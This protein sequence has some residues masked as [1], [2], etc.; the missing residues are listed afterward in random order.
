MVRRDGS[1]NGM[2]LAGLQLELRNNHRTRL[3]VRASIECRVETRWGDAVV[4]CGSCDA[5]GCWQVERGLKLT[6]DE[7]IYPVWRAEP[8]L[9][10]VDDA[11]EF[12]FVLVR[13]DGS[14][15]WEPLVNNR[16]LMLPSTAEEL[17]VVADWGSPSASPFAASPS[18]LLPS[19]AIGRDHFAIPSSVGS[20]VNSSVHATAGGGGY[21]GGG[22][23]DRSSDPASRDEPIGADHSLVERLL[24]VTHHLPL[25]L[26]RE[27][28]GS[29]RAEWD[30]SSLLATSVQGGR[31][32]LGALHL[33]V[34]FVGLTR[35]QVPPECE[36]QVA[37][38]CAA[39]NCVPV[40]LPP[41]SAGDVD[42][43]GFASQ[44]LWPLMHNQL[45]DRHAGGKGG[46]GTVVSRMWEAYVATNEAFAAR[47]RAALRPGDMVWVH[48]YHLLLLPAIL[49]G[50]MEGAA[51]GSSRDLFGRS[52]TAQT[53]ANSCIVSLFLHTPFPSPEVWR[54]VPYRKE[55]LQGE[56]TSPLPPS[57]LCPLTPVCACASHRHARGERGRLPPLRIRSS[58]YDLMP[59][60]ARSR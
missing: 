40:F 30:G 15:E 16:R 59:P 41:S 53:T 9:H 36:A 28:D 17:Q 45:P 23:V 10:G 60:T 58:L 39:F 5:L 42:S 37:E 56:T 50:S 54:V 33:E 21:G 8:L 38:A 3:F 6:T 47:V 2:Q 55:L 49:R 46:D 14:V 7:S 19:P 27:K 26:R 12:K 29:W 34:I 20:S 4:M 51:A 31:H 57:A 35:M 25:M 48:N 1:F 24:V 13:Q 18:P 22:S 43:I 32:L 44:V 52:A 11:L